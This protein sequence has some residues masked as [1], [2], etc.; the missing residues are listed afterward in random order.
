LERL[1]KRREKE[2][3]SPAR[4]RQIHHAHNLR[5]T[6]TNPIQIA[7]TYRSELFVTAV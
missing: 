6:S 1:T 5:R 7:N 2:L 4:C 3:N